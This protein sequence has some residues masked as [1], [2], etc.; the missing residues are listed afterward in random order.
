MKQGLIINLLK[1]MRPG[2]VTGLT[3]GAWTDRRPGFNPIDPA[4]ADS[5][6]NLFSRVEPNIPPKVGIKSS[7]MLL[8]KIRENLSRVVHANIS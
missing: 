7:I 3:V 4:E 8:K 1:G 6:D 5:E 2:A